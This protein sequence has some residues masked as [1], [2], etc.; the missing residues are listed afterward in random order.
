MNILFTCSGRRNYLLNYFKNELP[1]GSKIIAS[2]MQISAP[3]M[4]DAD[5]AVVAKSIYHPEYVQDIIDTCNKYS[6]DALISLNDLELPILAHHK[7][8][9][10]KN[11]LQC[12]PLQRVPVSRLKMVPPTAVLHIPRCLFHQRTKTTFE[13]EK[14]L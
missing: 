8:V 11:I 2:D 13:S 12:A 7:K 4:A 14:C 3:S 5:I 6:V 9:P 1:V 10:P